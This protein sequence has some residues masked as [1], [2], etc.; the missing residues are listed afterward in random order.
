MYKTY[1]LYPKEKKGGFIT[2]IPQKT[3]G[4]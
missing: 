4:L 3:Q 2:V 1:Y